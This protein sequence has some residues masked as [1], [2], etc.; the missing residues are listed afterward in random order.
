MTNIPIGVYA[1]LIGEEPL[2]KALVSTGIT[3]YCAYGKYFARKNIPISKYTW[4]NF[5]RE[6]VNLVSWQWAT[7]IP[8]T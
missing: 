6:G 2:V 8:T 7:L 1:S 3:G 5:P 4:M